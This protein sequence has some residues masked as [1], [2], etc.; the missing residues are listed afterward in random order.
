MFCGN[1]VEIVN[2]QREDGGVY[3]CTFTNTVGEI[4][5]LIKLVVEALYKWP[6]IIIIIIIII[7]IIIIYPPTVT[8]NGQ[9]LSLVAAGV[10]RHNL[11]AA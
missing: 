6:I 5:Q 4:S 1:R 7:T 8:R 9:K 11:A 3:T 2:L 10:Y